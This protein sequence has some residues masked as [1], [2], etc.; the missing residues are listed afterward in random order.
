M[1]IAALLG[2]LDADDGELLAQLAAQLDDSMLDEIAGADRGDGAAA[3]RAALLIIRDQLRIPA[4][5]Q[6][7]PQEVLELTRWSDPD[8]PRWRDSDAAARRGHVIRA[9]CCTALIRAGADPENPYGFDN[10]PDT[11]AQLVASLGVL[12]AP[13]QLAGLRFLA[14]RLA[15]LGVE[16]EE[17]PFYFLAI[18][19]LAL[20]V[21]RD[22][23]PR[24]IAD[25]VAALVVEEEAVRSGGW[26]FPPARSSDWL[27]GLL[28]GQR[29]DVWRALGNK[30]PGLAQR[31]D[32]EDVRR[33]VVG[34]A[35]RLGPP[36]P[37]WDP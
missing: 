31:I 30:L 7:E 37:T 8:D 19:I 35:E 1:T 18:L 20:E 10:E 27:L 6:W 33:S 34:I 25:L 13:Q 29:K 28:H 22:L 15:R 9:F 2:K 26:A 21:R 11:L 4:P 16:V 14:W 24:E 17:R 23:S 36:E 3:H 5:L 32:D 12:G